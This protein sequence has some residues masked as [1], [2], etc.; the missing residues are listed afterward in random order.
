MFLCHFQTVVYHSTCVCVTV[1]LKMLLCL[2][3][4]KVVFTPQLLVFFLQFDDVVLG[5]G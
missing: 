4:N 2:Q 3:Q 1:Y 5:Y